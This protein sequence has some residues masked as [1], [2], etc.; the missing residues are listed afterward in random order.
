M[1]DLL[2]VENNE[3]TLRIIKCLLPIMSPLV[4]P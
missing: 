1:R 4:N 3:N 2:G